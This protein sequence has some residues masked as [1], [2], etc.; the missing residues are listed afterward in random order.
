MPYHIHCLKE[1]LSNKQKVNHGYSLRAFARDLDM[2]S[3]TLS[4]VLSGKRKLPVKNIEKVLLKLELTPEAKHLFFES[5]YRSSSR[6]DSIKIDPSDN[7]FVLEQSQFK[8]IAEWEHYAILAMFNLASFQLNEE[9]V[10]QKLGLSLNRTQVVL[11]NLKQ[12]GLIKRDDTGKLVKTHPDLKTSEDVLSKG[13]Q[14]SHKETVKMSLDKLESTDVLKRDYSSTTL[15]I[16]MQKLPEAKQII[17]EFRRKMTELMK[18]GDQTE[19]YQLAIQFFP[20]SHLDK[21][22]Q[23]QQ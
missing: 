17:R 11:E 19:I 13:L 2:N 6:L 5:Y 8:V 3:S 21:N 18:E 14:E 7:R 20:L 4:Q 16:D 15:A 10:S 22:Q 12:A 23:E 1:E 9:T